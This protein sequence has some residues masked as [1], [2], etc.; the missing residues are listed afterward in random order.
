MI[1]REARELT[2]FQRAAAYVAPAHNGPLDA[3]FEARIKSDYRG[4]RERNRRMRLGFGSELPPNMVA[5]LAVSA[6]ERDARFEERRQTGGF[7]FFGAFYDIILDER[8]NAFAAEFVRGKIR[9]TVHDPETALRLS[10]RHTIG[11]KRLCVDSLG[12]YDA[13]NSRTCGSST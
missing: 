10:P 11:C 2:V 5:A 1:A 12:Y 6:E 3:T 13:F 4:F 9:A 8:A 7:A